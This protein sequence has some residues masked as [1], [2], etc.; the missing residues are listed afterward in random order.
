[1]SEQ[2]NEHPALSQLLDYLDAEL[3]T[4]DQATI[5]AHLKQC[6]RCQE[7]LAQTKQL[8]SGMKGQ[9]VAEPSSSQW[10]TW[11]CGVVS[12][13]TKQGT[14]PQAFWQASFSW[15][16]PAVAVGLATLAF[17]LVLSFPDQRAPLTPSGASDSI[18]ARAPDVL[19]DLSLV[20]MDFDDASDVILL[21][22]LQQLTLD[23][24]HSLE[25]I[26]ID[27]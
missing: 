16:W 13:I 2:M 12:E 19:S 23:E 25:Q 6:V 8:V 9:S 27:L 15:R 17:W 11:Q 1:M 4:T 14:P 18:E 22:E 20:L 7:E 24:L 21:E 3:S 5:T 26:L 10:A